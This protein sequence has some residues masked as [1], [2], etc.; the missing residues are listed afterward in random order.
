MTPSHAQALIA[1]DLAVCRTGVKGPAKSGSAG[2]SAT[3][4]ALTGRSRLAL[5]EAGVVFAAR[6]LSQ[7]P[8]LVVRCGDQLAVLPPPVLA[9]APRWNAYDG[10]LLYGGQL[11]KRFRRDAHTQRKVL[12]AFEVAAWASRIANPLAGTRGKRRL[13][14]TI[15]GLHAGQR[16]LVLRFR[17][18]GRGGVTWEAVG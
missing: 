10:E 5:T 3:G 18:D 4:F 13:R 1:V 11:V 17:A 9:R 14:Y 2:P 6:Q 8:P 12:D 7:G 16:P 15:E